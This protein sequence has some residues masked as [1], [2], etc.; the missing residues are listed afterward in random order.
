MSILV[1][2]VL[3]TDGKC[4]KILVNKSDPFYCYNLRSV[5]AINLR[6]QLTCS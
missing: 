6:R 3:L 1:D 5:V 4:K 2:Q